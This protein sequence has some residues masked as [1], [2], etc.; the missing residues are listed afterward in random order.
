M[1]VELPSGDENWNTGSVKANV[2]LFDPK[3]RPS[4]ISTTALRQR[5]SVYSK[6]CLTCLRGIVGVSARFRAS[7][8]SRLSRLFFRT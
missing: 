6:S 1:S 2:R 4:E 8:R 3:P 5:M 7:I